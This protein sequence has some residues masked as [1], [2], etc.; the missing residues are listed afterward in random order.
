MAMTGIRVNTRRILLGALAAAC[1]LLAMTGVGS[2]QAAQ[3]W[4]HVDAS[5]RPTPLATVPAPEV[6]KINTETV[7]FEPEE[8]LIAK[9][10]ID[11]QVVAC[12]ANDSET[13]GYC[14]ALFGVKGVTT[15]EE[16]QG[17]LE[18]PDAYGKGNVEVR[19]GPASSPSAS[20]EVITPGGPAPPVSVES[21][22]NVYGHAS[23]AVLQQGGSGK[24]VLLATNVGN[25]SVE[26]ATASVTI[27][28][29]L[30]AGVGVKATSIEGKT[31][32]GSVTRAPVEC[33]Q[34]AGPCTFKGD[35]PPYEAIE[36][37]VTVVAQRGAK[38]GEGDTA[39]VE[40]GGAGSSSSLLK[41]AYGDEPTFGVQTYEMNAEGEGGAPVRKAG[42]HPFQLTTSTIM[43]QNAEGKPVDLA[44]DLEFELP[45]GLVGNPTAY[46]QCSLGEFMTEL[47]GENGCRPETAIGVADATIR[48]NG[49]IETLSVPVFNLEPEEGEPARFGF[50][51]A[52]PVVLDTSVRTGKG[53]G[54][55]VAAHN[56]TELAGFLGAQVTFWGVPGSPSH[57]Q[58]RGWGCLRVSE[59]E[60]GYTCKPLEERNPAPFLTMPTSCSGPM[61]APLLANSWQRPGAFEEFALEEPPPA[62]QACNQL[63]FEPTIKATPDYGEASRPS[64]LS[65]DVHVPQELQVVANG[66]AE[67]EVK[68]IKVVLPKGVTV[69]PGGAGG[70]EACTE[71]DVGY[72]GKELAGEVAMEF[73][74]PTL[75]EPFCPKQAK[76]GTVTI[77]TPLLPNPLEGAVYLA[78]PAPTGEA[79]QNPYRS[80]LAMYLV[81]EDPVSGTLVKLPMHVS[82]N[83]ETGQ[84][85]TTVESPQ[86][87]FED[88]EL[89]FFGGS[90]A[91]LATPGLCGSYTTKAVFTPWSGQEPVTS[92]STFNITSGP[93]GS[94][95]PS[96]PK[97]FTPEF[98]VGTTNNQAD[99]FSP[100]TMT[101]ARKDGEQTLGSLDMT[102]P[103]G[104]AGILSSVVQCGE[105]Q[106]DA[107]TCPAA[108]QI[109][110]VTVQAGVGNEPIT[111]P[112][113]GKP[114][115]P[116]YLTGPYEGA[117]FGL[118]V[119]VHPEAGPFNLEENGHPV[120]V[121]AKIEVNPYTAQA[122]V[123][124]GA[125]PTILR[126]IPL[127]VRTI[128]VTIDR[129]GFMFD[130]TNCAAMSIAGAV[131]SSEGASEGVSS[132]FQAANCATLPFKPTFTVS[133]QGR[134]SKADGASLTVKL[135]SKGGPQA[136][137]GEANIRSVKVDLPK[138]LPSR[139]TTLQKAC[140]AAV[141]NA[142]PAGCPA[143][144][145]VGTATAT[146]PIF[147]H[148]LTG[149][150]Y[151]V[152]HGGEAFPDLEIVL[153]GEGVTLIL[154][155][156]T[157]IK[158][159][160]TSSTFRTVPDAPISSFELKLPT[161]PY[162][163]LGTNLPTS[164]K[165]S[166]CGQKLA[167][168][169]AFAGQ[170]GAEIHTSTPISVEGCK[171][172]ITVVKRS[173]K[174]AT[175]TLEVSV[176]AAGRL[177]ATGKGLSKASEKASRASTVTV[178]LTLTNGEAAFLARHPGRRLKAKIDLRF[179]PKKGA[180][181]KTTT[182]V[183]IG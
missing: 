46:P 165:Y 119:V 31:V 126:G 98:N 9:V 83:E 138:Q 182:T 168:P 56:L 35:L 163:I 91:P 166:L 133:T 24:I 148:P 15:A 173:V 79:G 112:Q 143:A 33:V 111:L 63:R 67:S 78:S 142:N 88:A 5:V 153:Q 69:N 19:G 127:D 131:A 62:M 71:G 146:T 124:S 150:A 105:A 129:A 141:F 122:S 175:A 82:L 110:H 154:D 23:A 70:L 160:I 64:G 118:A 73:F 2:A 90:R 172:A 10:E 145:N 113:A 13:V 132:R 93:N 54:V 117:P 109:G 85:V 167:M 38:D 25:A 59:G 149:P 125:M 128:D 72:E 164:A 99:A 135:A 40:G 34:P 94:P 43:N 42:A 140:V 92:T 155:G 7:N 174:G 106:A 14:E 95:C 89:H 121:R 179:T 27:S 4:W 101:L 80:L 39:A 96:D 158:K 170:N 52:V 114:E 44:K 86:L 49:T 156:N 100:F 103:P 139:L 108:S 37:D 123:S 147:S 1:M 20:F 178:K 107:G 97:P 50:Y 157:D 68:Q 36:V 6:Q 136:G 181:L 171:P 116:V 162:S 3:A 144:S 11:G 87:P 81:A 183:L 45:D 76:I 75:P 55:T 28:N 26:G 48:V 137:G 77:H 161:G 30:P 120:V 176:P 8:Y 104:L 152:S 180:R 61:R 169:T 32:N 51:P 47:N 151:L 134:I 102:L 12:L 84:V 21:Y 22:E 65:V 18:A 130:P 159:G 16:L 53:Y 74:S 58:Q 17:A 41:L 57:D 177:V 66:T 60:L 115:D 29:T